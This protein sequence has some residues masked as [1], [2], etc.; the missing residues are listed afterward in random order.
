VSKLAVVRGVDRRL[1]KERKVYQ[2]EG[3]ST[4]VNMSIH[5]NNIQ[6]LERAVL[7]RVFFVKRLNPK[8]NKE[9]FMFPP[10][11]KEN[12]FKE[13][14]S[15][16]EE[17]V[18]RN[19]S[20][21]TPYSY[22]GFVDTYK[23]RKHTIYANAVESLRVKPLDFRRDSDIKVFIKAE[24]TN[25]TE[26]PDP[27]PRVISP[28][29][30]RMNVEI[31]CYLKKIEHQLYKSIKYI[32]RETT[33]S[34]GLNALQTA[35]LIETKWKKF[36]H[37]VAVG[38]DAKRFDE[39][40]STE[41][42]QFEHR[43][44]NKFWKC[45]KLRKLLSTQLRSR[46]FGFC[47]DGKLKYV[48]DGR[49]MSGAMNTGLG[50]C[51][52]MCAMVHAYMKSTGIRKYS[53]INNGDDCVVIFEKRHLLKFSV[54]LESYFLDFG[55]S[56][57]VEEPV[58]ILEQIVFCQAQPVWTPDGYIMVR[59]PKIA[60]AK[61]CIC[62]K[63]LNN[64]KTY[65]RWVGSVGKCGMSLSGG[66][67]IM[68]NF[69]N[70]FIRASNGAKEIINELTLESGLAI[71]AKGMHRNFSYIC[72]QTRFSFYLA[73]NILPDM[74]IELENYYDSNTPCFRNLSKSN[75]PSVPVWWI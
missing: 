48:V 17:L 62:V 68:Q 14:L 52:I 66:I 74:Q 46:C 65:D 54:S 21:T 60:I 43:I 47:P 1:P 49:R 13:R 10:V 8:T 73:F 22:D 70:S 3:M 4:D 36:H 32:F 16:F 55:F 67:P 72:E 58:Y 57:T 53:L 19:M 45:P 24:K 38:L 37:P 69:Y 18:V 50:N 75:Y 44:Y 15:Y 27:V 63:P 61:D 40:V 5:N 6:N 25:L 59:Q 20:P 2:V 51:V 7:E 41:A 11:P 12:V 30:T 23:G 39:H 26:K 33:I 29:N 64:N 42:L 31:G 34:K 71:M 35:R 56:M 9:E 28:C